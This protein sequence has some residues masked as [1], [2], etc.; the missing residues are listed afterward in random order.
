MVA[1]VREAGARI[2]QVIEEDLKP[3]NV[4]APG[5]FTNAVMTILSVGGSIISVELMQAVAQRRRRR[6]YRCTV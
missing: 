5:A 2:V 6:R 4:L 1:F 3:R